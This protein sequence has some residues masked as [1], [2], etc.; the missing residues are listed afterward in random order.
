MLSQHNAIPNMSWIQAED[1]DYFIITGVTY[2]LKCLCQTVVLV[3]YMYSDTGYLAGGKYIYFL[4]TLL[5]LE[6][7]VKYDK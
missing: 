4:M 2:I 7:A 3:V 5:M 1:L 6:M